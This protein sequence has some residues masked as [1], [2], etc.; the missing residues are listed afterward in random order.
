MPSEE[1]LYRFVGEERL[2]QV[3]GEYLPLVM[4]RQ[5]FAVKGPAIVQSAG[6]RYALWVDQLIGQQ[7]VVVKN[8]EQ[9]YRKVEGV[10]GAT[11]LGDGG[12]ALI[13]DVVELASEQEVAA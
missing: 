6:C 12:V 9:N 7:Q 4:L 2:L 8:L 1:M 13:L 11:I 5:R 3:R 10:L